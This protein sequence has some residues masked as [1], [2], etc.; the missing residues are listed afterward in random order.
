MKMN[1]HLPPAPERLPLICQVE[2]ISDVYFGAL[3]SSRS[4]AT[5]KLHSLCPAFAK[6]DF[7]HFFYSTNE[8][9]I[10]NL[11]LSCIKEINIQCN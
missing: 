9:K 3:P 2:P 11:S 10:Y 4:P 7:N 1:E 8:F 6:S 5:V